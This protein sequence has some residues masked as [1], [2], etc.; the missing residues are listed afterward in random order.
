MNARTKEALSLIFPESYV[1]YKQRREGGFFI[2]DDGHLLTRGII[3]A[4]V[5]RQLSELGYT[6]K[7][8]SNFCD[9]WVKKKK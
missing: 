5:E 4:D 3:T 1:A 7:E 2:N 8:S 9:V 6:L